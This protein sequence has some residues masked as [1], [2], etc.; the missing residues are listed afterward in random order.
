MKLLSDLAK[1]HNIKLENIG[2]HQGVVKKK[3]ERDGRVSY[4]TSC[5]GK[6]LINRFDQIKA[7]LSKRGIK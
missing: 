4:G 6:N 7:E 5:P 3:I 2:Y 1:A